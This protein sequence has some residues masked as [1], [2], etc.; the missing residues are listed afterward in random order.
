MFGSARPPPPAR[1]RSSNLG[2]FPVLA[3]MC[4]ASMFRA[5]TQRRYGAG[6]S[7]RACFATDAFFVSVH[8]NGFRRPRR[9]IRGFFARPQ[10]GQLARHFRTGG[11]FRRSHF[12]KNR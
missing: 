2:V 5:D 1:R 4:G 8:A 12:P 3:M 11:H 6:R 10:G 9:V 7:T